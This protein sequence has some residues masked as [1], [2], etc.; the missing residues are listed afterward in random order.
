MYI[1]IERESEKELASTRKEKKMILVKNNYI[2]IL[3]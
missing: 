2:L 1:Y 3:L